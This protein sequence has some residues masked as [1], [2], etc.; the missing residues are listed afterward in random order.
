MSN[1]KPTTA[2]VQVSFRVS[3]DLRKQ[4]KIAAA[5]RDMSVNQFLTQLV[6]D[7]VSSCTTQG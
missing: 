6:E 4:I 1:Q 2:E 5:E 7:R 3:P